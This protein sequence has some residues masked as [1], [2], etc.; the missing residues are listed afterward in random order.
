MRRNFFIKKSF[1]SSFAWR[2]AALVALEAFLMTLLTLYLSRGTL[3]TSYAGG[4]LRIEHTSQYFLP[5]LL[6]V[7]S[8]AAVTVAIVGMLVFIILSHRIAGPVYRLQKSV[9]DIRGGNLTHRIQL[10]RK[11]E[12]GE[13]AGELNRLCE[14]LDGRV[15]EMKREVQRAK[16]GETAEALKRLED[17]ANG[18]KTSS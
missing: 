3:T 8:I 16:G 14:L 17:L 9:E 1:Q 4:Q 12:L 7:S 13:L 6:L 18:F 10:R 5:T 15:A 11:D 2:F